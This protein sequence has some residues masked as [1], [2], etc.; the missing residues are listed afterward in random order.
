MNQ[1]VYIIDGGVGT[2][3]QRRGS[4]MDPCCWSSAVHLQN[5]EVLLSIHRDYL[6]AGATILSTNTFMASRHLLEQSGIGHFE[7]VNRAAVKLA[8]E[9]RTRFAESKVLIAGCMSTFPPF[10]QTHDLPRG[11]QVDR[12]FREQALLLADA[13]VDVLLAEMLVDSETAVSLLNACCETG[14]PVWVGMSAMLDDKTGELM[15][16]RPPGKLA[17]LPH[18]RFDSL[19]GNLSELPIDIL[20]VMHTPVEVMDSALSEVS[21]KWSGPLLAYAK[22]GMATQHEWEFDTSIPPEEYADQAVHWINDYPVQ[23]VGGCCGTQ[24]EH[25]EALS[26]RIVVG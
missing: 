7:E 17:D 21:R 8:L 11:K 22:T 9:A 24:P 18:E 5:P 13:G 20:G 25:I 1:S 10:D 12:N 3:L 26:R 14:L 19:L 2:E 6:Q 23:I 15:T 4:S 16:F